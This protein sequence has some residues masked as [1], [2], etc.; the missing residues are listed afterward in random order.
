M[1]IAVGSANKIKLDA[2]RR[3]F[4]QA[5]FEDIEVVGQDV[6]SGIPEQPYGQEQ[7][8]LGAQNRV[9]ETLKY[10]PDADFVVGIESGVMKDN[11]DVAIVYC[12]SKDKEEYTAQSEAVLFPSKS[13]EEARTRGFDKWT[14]GKVMEEQGVV[15]NNKDPHLCLSGKSRT[16]YL[17]AVIKTLAEEIFASKPLSGFRL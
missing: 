11:N 14:V 17:I 10:F 4:E 2:V 8:L 5:G 3:G 7:T 15:K 16:D 6:P 13:V 1:L 12:L 9:H